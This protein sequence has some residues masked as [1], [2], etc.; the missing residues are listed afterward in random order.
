MQELYK[1]LVSKDSTLDDIVSSDV[2]HEFHTFISDLKAKLEKSRTAQL[3]IMFMN[4]VSVVRLFIRAERTA[5]WRLH[6]IA[7]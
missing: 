2:L 5:N 1:N 3:W 6:L 4:F 7:Y